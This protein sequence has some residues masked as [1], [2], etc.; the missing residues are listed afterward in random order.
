MWRCSTTRSSA[1]RLLDGLWAWRKAANDFDKPP[2]VRL[3]SR[4]EI[5][6]ET[7]QLPRDPFVGP[8]EAV[9]AEKATGRICTEQL[10][11]YSASYPGGRARR[12]VQ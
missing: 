12:A 9:P 2:P 3:P 5:E 1:E 6:L 11:P 7:A 8:V 10:T 4:E